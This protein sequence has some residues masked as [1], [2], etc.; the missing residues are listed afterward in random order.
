MCTFS[1]WRSCYALSAGKICTKLVYT[2]SLKLSSG[3]I[4][5]RQSEWVKTDIKN[6]SVTYGEDCIFKGTE[7]HLGSKKNAFTRMACFKSSS[8]Q[9]EQKDLV[10]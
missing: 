2:L 1:R 10:P 7:T 4:N 5:C 9:E 6:E 8:K 3:I